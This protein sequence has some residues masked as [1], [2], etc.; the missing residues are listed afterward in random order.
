[1]PR[2]RP[3]CFI[4]LFTYKLWRALKS[5]LFIHVILK[6]KL[7]CLLRLPL[8]KMPQHVL[9]P[10]MRGVVMQKVENCLKLLIL[11]V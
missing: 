5:K 3:H 6:T 8:K 11:R 2:K 9:M 4:A 10:R 1:M 7:R